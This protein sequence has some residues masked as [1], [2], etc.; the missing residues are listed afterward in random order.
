MCFVILMWLHFF[1]KSLWNVHRF[2]NLLFSGNLCF[3]KLGLVVHK[4]AF[5]KTK[6]RQMK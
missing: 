3:D 4:V 1:A 6:F 2:T 5:L